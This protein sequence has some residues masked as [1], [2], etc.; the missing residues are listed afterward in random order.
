MEAAFV[1]DRIRML[2]TGREP[3]SSPSAN[4]PLWPFVTARLTY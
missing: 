1:S 2:P 3:R 4:E